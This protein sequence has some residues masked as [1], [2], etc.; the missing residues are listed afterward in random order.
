M[1]AID[2]EAPRAKRIIGLLLHAQNARGILTFDR[3]RSVSGPSGVIPIPEMTWS[4]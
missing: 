3:R 1:A 4:R 2:P